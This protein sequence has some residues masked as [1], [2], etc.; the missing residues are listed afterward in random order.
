VQFTS[1][2]SLVLGDALGAVQTHVTTTGAN[3]ELVLAHNAKVVV[4]ADAVL[5]HFRV[6]GLVEAEA[7]ESLSEFFHERVVLQSCSAFPIILALQVALGILFLVKF[8]GRSA[9]KK[10]LKKKHEE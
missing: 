2:A 8:T 6:V 4:G 3:F 1:T 10:Y 9:E 5:E 7:F